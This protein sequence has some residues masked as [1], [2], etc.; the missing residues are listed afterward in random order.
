MSDCCGADSSCAARNYGDSV[1]IVFKLMTST[2]IKISLTGNVVI[3]A[4]GFLCQCRF[5]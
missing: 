4:G 2:D 1:A 3:I 5:A